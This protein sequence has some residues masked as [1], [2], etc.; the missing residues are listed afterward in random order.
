[1]NFAEARTTIGPV[2]SISAFCTQ[3][4]GLNEQNWQ[5]W[6]WHDSLRAALMA[7]LAAMLLAGFIQGDQRKP[8]SLQQ[9]H[10]FSYGCG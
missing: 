10:I 8:V 7:A 4:G 9:G 2:C 6:K 1:M 3:S 5:A